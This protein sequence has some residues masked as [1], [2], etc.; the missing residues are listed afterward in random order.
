MKTLP[1]SEAE[2]RRAVSQFP[3]PFHLYNAEA[4]RQ[5]ARRLMKAF[6]WAGGFTNFFAVKACPNPY[7]LEILMEEGFGADCSSASELVLAEMVGITGE[8]IMYT[9]N[10]TS[11]RELVTAV[12]EGVIVNLDDITFI[13]FLEKH[14]GIPE[15]L[16]L[17]YNPGPLREGNALIGKPEEA[18]YGFTGKQLLE[19]Y[20]ILRDK[21]VKRFGL[22]TMVAS[23]GLDPQY[24]IATAEMLFSLVAEISEELG[25][26]FEFVN[27]GG[28]IGIPY[29][30]DQNPVDLEIVS[31]GIKDLYKD[32]IIGNGLDPL[33]IYMENGRMIV[34]PFGCLVTTAIHPMTKYRDYVGVDACINAL[35]RYALYGSYH[36]ITVVGKEN[37]PLTKTYCVTGSLCENNDY[38]ATDRLLPEIV[39]G[40]ILVIHDTGAHGHAMGSNYNGKP[41]PAEILMDPDGSFRQIRREE[42]TADLFKTLDF[43]KLRTKSR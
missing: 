24:F 31:A 30:P 29:M 21:G 36:H 16:C 43:S 20:K 3:T 23:N 2:I 42:T 15:L 37:D 22:H 4:I 41:R 12:R 13:P 9:S 18:K 28:G 1:F 35:M 11:A 39:E 32:I 25:I 7:V 38:F 26:C 5:N 8:M 33:K 10:D 34:G 17:R 14:A 27:L 6:E 19:G 40:D